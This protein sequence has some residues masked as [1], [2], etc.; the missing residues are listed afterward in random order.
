MHGKCLD[1]KNIKWSVCILTVQDW[2]EDVFPGSSKNNTIKASTK[3]FLFHRLR[4]KK[5]KNNK[6]SLKAHPEPRTEDSAPEP[7]APLSP[8]VFLNAVDF[9]PRR[10]RGSWAMMIHLKD[11]FKVKHVSYD[12]ASRPHAVLVLILRFSFLVDLVTHEVTAKAF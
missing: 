10:S 4:S 2:D 11:T 1:I 6:S 7:D 5:Q 8:K 3:L 12:Q 9:P